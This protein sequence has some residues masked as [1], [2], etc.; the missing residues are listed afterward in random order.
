MGALDHQGPWKERPPAGRRQLAS[1]AKWHRSE[2]ERLARE[3]A[4]MTPAHQDAI[5][6]AAVQRMHVDH[7][8]NL[9]LAEELEAYLEPDPAA[10]DGHVGLF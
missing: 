9:Q 8:T 7:D 5:G 1:D 3:L 6:T 4:D 10:G 2:A